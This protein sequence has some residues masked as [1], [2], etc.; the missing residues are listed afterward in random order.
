MQHS[1]WAARA[2][3]YRAARAAARVGVRH[4]LVHLLLAAAATAAGAAWDAGYRVADLHCTRSGEQMA[5][6]HTHGPN[7]RSRI[8]GCPRGDELP[9]AAAPGRWHGAT[10]RQEEQ[11]AAEIRRHNCRTYGCGVVCTYGDW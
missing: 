7:S 2:A 9:A 8:D 11:R 4:P 1:I 6:K 3:Q 5:T 10:R